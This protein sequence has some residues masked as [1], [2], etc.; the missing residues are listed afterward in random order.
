MKHGGEGV[1][2]VAQVD[3]VE[4]SVGAEGAGGL[5]A[6]VGFDVD[7]VE[8]PVALG[9]EGLG[10]S[11]TDSTGCWERKERQRNRGSAMYEFLF[12]S[13]LPSLFFLFF[14]SFFIIKK[15]LSE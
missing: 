6:L 3:A 12:I 1:V 13:T 9:C 14:F 5:D 7:E 11:E 15:W 10:Y 2:I 8:D 4:S